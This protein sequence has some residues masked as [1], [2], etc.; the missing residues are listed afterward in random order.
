MAGTGNGATLTL[1]TTGSVGSI[2]EMTLPEWTLEKIE[3]SHLGTTNFKTYVPGDLVE[4][5]ELTATVIFDT[6]VSVPTISSTTGSWDAAETVT[7]TFPIQKSTNTTAATLVGTGFITGYSF[8]QMANDTL[9]V[10]TIT[11]SFDGETEPA[12]SAET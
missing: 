10:A 5:G 4:P 2:Q 9:Q 1:G 8:P 3:T 11:I 6:E 12:F 7:V